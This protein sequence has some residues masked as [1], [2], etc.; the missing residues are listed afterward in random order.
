MRADQWLML[1][2][3]GLGVYAVYRMTRAEASPLPASPGDSARPTPLPIP[4]GP[5]PALPA[6][7][8][9]PSNLSVVT[10]PVLKL[11]PA[12]WYH[13]R[14]ETVSKNGQA[15]SVF[16]P[17]DNRADLV[18]ALTS[19]G[20]GNVSVFMTPKEASNDIFQP[21]AFEGAGQGTRWFRARWPFADALGNLSSTSISRPDGLVTLW[22]AAP[23]AVVSGRPR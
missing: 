18:T 4:S 1:G 5:L 8:T 12:S 14:V 22:V 2:V 13:G 11:T 16:F 15:S 6:D 3:V 21:F 20:F 10:G 7:S 19:L 23:P 17:A 9:P